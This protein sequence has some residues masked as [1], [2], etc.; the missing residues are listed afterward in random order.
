MIKTP[1]SPYETLAQIVGI[2][3]GFC[4]KGKYIKEEIQ[5][6]WNLFLQKYPYCVDY[7]WTEGIFDQFKTVNTIEINETNEIREIDIQ[8]IF[9]TNQSKEK[10]ENE[11]FIEITEI[12]QAMRIIIEES[13]YF[14]IQT[15]SV[16]KLKSASLV[17]SSIEIQKEWYSFFGMYQCHSRTDLTSLNY[18]VEEFLNLFDENKMINE[19][20]NQIV[21]ILSYYPQYVEN[22][23]S[24]SIDKRDE[25]L[26]T[27][28]TNVLQFDCSQ[29]K[30]EEMKYR[31]IREG[32][33][34]QTSETLK[35]NK[36]E[37]TTFLQWCKNHSLSPQAVF[38]AIQLKVYNNLFERKCIST[39]QKEEMN[40]TIVF[41][42]PYDC[43][44]LVGITTP[45]IGLYAEDIYPMYP[46][47]FLSLSIE[48]MAQ[49][50]TTYVRNITTLTASEFDRYRDGYYNGHFAS[51][52]FPI[53]CFF[54]NLGKLKV[55]ER[56][57]PTMKEKFIDFQCAGCSRIAQNSE[58]VSISIHSFG[59]FDG[60]CNLCASYNGKIEYQIVVK[61]LNAI[62]EMIINLN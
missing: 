35:L 60:S 59:L 22:N 15:R 61:T 51:V 58:D 55:M 37:T 50:L 16:G 10:N 24:P 4:I 56:L 34:A 43:R 44:N 32:L 9:E 30:G 8:K 53:S 7:E 13:F 33:Y 46:E 54:S 52:T 26:K 6:K 29:M 38:N 36:N 21:P 1:E 18:L 2:N 39:N 20:D 45:T 17:F 12:N 49:E 11:E 25:I 42:F 62:K 48:E 31:E 40:Q 57:T 47:S 19:K 41:M 5:N 14:S 27:I 28:P 23:C 3:C